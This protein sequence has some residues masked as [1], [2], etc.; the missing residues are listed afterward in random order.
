MRS[1]TSARPAALVLLDAPADALMTPNPVSIRA[2]AG[3]KE[4]M[5]LLIDRGIS[6]APVID[7]AGR[8]VGVLSRTDLLIH[9]REAVHNLGPA[10]CAESLPDGFHVEAVDPTSVEEV[11]TPA[12]FAVPANCPAASVVEQLLDLKVHRL[13]VVDALG[14][15][16]GVISPGD[17]LRHLRPAGETR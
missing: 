6:A 11:M 1:A 14:V 4:A 9:E 17:V 3:V 10:D 15:L 8:P 13:F 7:D 5:A 16:V 2:R 12:V